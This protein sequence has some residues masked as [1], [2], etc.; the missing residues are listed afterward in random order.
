MTPLLQVEGL[1][2]SFGGLQVLHDVSFTLQEGE[3]VGLIGPNGAGKT[4]LLNCLT[5]FYRPDSGS[6]RFRGE[7]LVGMR[8]GAIAAQGISRT[9]QEAAAMGLVG[10][11]DLMLLARERYL[12]RGVLRYATPLVK[13]AEREAVARVRE[14]AAKVGVL[15]YVDRNVMLDDL[16]YGVRKLADLGRALSCDASLLLMDEPA[17]GLHRA[18]K[19]MMA[20]LIQDMRAEGEVTQ[21]LVDH[22][23]EFVSSLC[24]R[25]VVLNAGA[26][27]AEGD[28][29][30]VL[31]MREVV[32]S[33]IGAS[34]EEVITEVEEEQELA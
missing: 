5:G 19:E 6:I 7:E 11:R 28:V 16:P 8:T 2:L 34:V 21:L 25:L 22:D 13:A 24:D 18:E 17:A 31:S 1:N 26:L 3:V 9:F 14:S 27:I 23:L 33:Y 15:E 29:E 32:E 30:T 20:K 10:A 4:A 12:P